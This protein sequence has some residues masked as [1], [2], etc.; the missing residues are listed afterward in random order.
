MPVKAPRRPQYTIDALH[1]A[2]RVLDAFLLDGQA[3]MSLAEISREVSLNKSRVFRIAST[4]QQRGFLERDPVS[5]EYRLGLKFIEF[6]EAARRRISLIE[7]AEPVLTDL[8]SATGET[9][10]LGVRDGLDAVCVAMRESRHPVRLTAEVGRRVPLYVGGVPKVLLAFLS[11]QEQEEVLRRLRLK[12]IT[13][14]TITSRAALRRRLEAIRRQGYAVTADDL[15]LG[16]TSVAAPVLGAGDELIAAI[17]VA[18]PSERFTPEVV[19]RAVQFTLDGAR[20]IAHAIG[21]PAERSHP[22]QV[23]TR[24]QATPGGGG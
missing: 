22:V 18:G 3:S 17:S 11:P 15:D 19:A 24:R 12:P 23:S 20:R 9:V 6:G 4:L 1:Q 13:P 7:A 5:R 14:M 21:R 2:L 16:A 8:A 10:F